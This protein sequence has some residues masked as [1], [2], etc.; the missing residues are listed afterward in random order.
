[1]IGGRFQHMRGESC[2]AASC[3][4]FCGGT[5]ACMHGEGQVLI[6]ILPMCAAGGY[7]SLL[8]LLEATL[9]VFIF[10]IGTVCN[11][12]YYLSIANSAYAY[13]KRKKCQCKYEFYSAVPPYENKIEIIL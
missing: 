12:F 6:V 11:A 13:Y 9:Y 2:V 5:V 8:L 7:I 1:M 4:S 10:G 3:I